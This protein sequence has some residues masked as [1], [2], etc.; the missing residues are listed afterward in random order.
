MLDFYCY[1]HLWNFW[2]SVAMNTNFL[3][4]MQT[5]SIFFCRRYIDFYMKDVGTQTNWKWCLFHTPTNWLWNFKWITIN[6]NNNFSYNNCFLE[7]VNVRWL[8][9]FK[10]LFKKPFRFA[11][12]LF[13]SSSIFL[14]LEIPWPSIFICRDKLSTAFYIRLERLDAKISKM[15]LQLD[16]FTG[17]KLSKINKLN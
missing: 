11:S 7:P 10:W 13:F 14:W 16:S 12:V 15:N 8:F 4:W 1:W 5:I 2:K 9:F 17:V 3:T 6:N